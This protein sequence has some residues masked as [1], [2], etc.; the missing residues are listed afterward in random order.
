M[1]DVW[2]MMYE[3]CMWS[4][5]APSSSSCSLPS[6]ILQYYFEENLLILYNKLHTYQYR[7]GVIAYY[8]RV[9]PINLSAES[10]R[11]EQMQL[12][13]R[14]ASC[15]SVVPLGFFGYLYCSH[16]RTI[17]DFIAV[18]ILSRLTGTERFKVWSWNDWPILHKINI[19]CLAQR[20]CL[21]WGRVLFSLRTGSR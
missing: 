9:S 11:N 13:R 10:I 19:Y 7:L 1:Y 12:W 16:K 15:I 21:F 20:L 5:R 8:N 14:M 18:P 17:D 3:W 4:V 6:S 2:C